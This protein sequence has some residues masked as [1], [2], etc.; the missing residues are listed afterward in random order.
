MRRFPVFGE[1]RRLFVFGRFGEICGLSPAID[2]KYADGRC[3]TL[4]HV[5]LPR[6]DALLFKWQHGP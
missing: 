6:I 5:N 4:I 2:Q 3:A 1:C